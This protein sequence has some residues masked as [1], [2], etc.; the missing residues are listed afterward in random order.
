MLTPIR[1][2]VL[3]CGKIAQVRHIPEYATNPN[4]VLVG[5]YDAV[6]ERAEEMVT[7]YGGKAFATAEKLLACEDI[8]AVSICTPNFT[9]AALTVAALRSGKHVLCEKPMA[10]T[11]EEC[12][13]MIEAAREAN[14]LL[15]IA[16]NQR[17]STLHQRAKELLD[18]GA[19]GKPL[20]FQ[21][22][23]GH[24]GPDHWSIHPGTDSWFFDKSRSAFGA[25]ADLG[26]HKL[27]LIHFLLNDKTAQ[28]Q[29]MCGVLDKKDAGGNPVSVEDNAVML[30]RL[31]SGVI[32]TVT[33]SWTRYGVEDND[34]VIYGTEGQLEICDKEQSIRVR[35]KNRNMIDTPMLKQSVSGVIDAFINAI[36][37]GEHTPIHADEVLPAM[38]AIFAAVQA[39]RG[40]Q[41]MCE[42]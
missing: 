25:I 35:Q 2:G 26:I 21:T 36:L 14:K 29:A 6:P 18:E 38:Q 41:I 9:H 42:V 17:Y 3:G 8:D 15:L 4:A 13:E 11:P 23:F 30:C 10:T 16:H 24:G 33:V 32:G 7:C 27:D 37:T 5:F 1:I 28:I 12:E 40:K 20:T 34:T 31:K 39:T 22:A 19:I